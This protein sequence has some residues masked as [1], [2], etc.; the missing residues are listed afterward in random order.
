[1]TVRLQHR[2][3]P[4]RPGKIVSPFP[5]VAGN[6][7]P[8]HPSRESSRASQFT[9]TSCQPSCSWTSVYGGRR[10]T[11]VCRVL[12]TL[13]VGSRPIP[14]SRMRRRSACPKFL[15]SWPSLLSFLYLFLLGSFPRNRR[16]FTIFDFHHYYSNISPSL[17]N[18]MS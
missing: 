11:T 4:R 3:Q 7:Q 17:D 9:L 2:P 6:S 10:A 13:S 18:T 15:S 8:A 1:M 5:S 16:V 12:I 14:F